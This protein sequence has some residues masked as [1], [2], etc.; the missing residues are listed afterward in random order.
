MG[1]TV[2]LSWREK[3]GSLGRQRVLEFGEEYEGEGAMQ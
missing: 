3:D 1:M 2:S